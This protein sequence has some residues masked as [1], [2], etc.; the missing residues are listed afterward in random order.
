MESTGY[1]V[2]VLAN[3]PSF[4][5]WGSRH[6]ENHRF[7]F[8]FC[9]GSIIGREEI[10]GQFCCRRAVLAT[11]PSFRCFCTVVP[12]LFLVPVFGTVVP[13]LHPRSGFG[14]P[15]N[16]HQ[17]HPFGNHRFANPR[18]STKKRDVTGSRHRAQ[19]HEKKRHMY[20]HK[21]F[22]LVTAWARESLLTGGRGQVP[23]CCV[24]NARNITIVFSA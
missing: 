6:I 2:P 3:V 16:I 24:R 20:R 15:G 8:F 23:V 11:V 17:N 21:R 12:L 5:F 13:F 4:R 10:K 9:Q 19:A 14:G 22:C 1:P 18:P 7:F